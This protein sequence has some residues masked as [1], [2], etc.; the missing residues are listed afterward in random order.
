[1][2]ERAAREDRH[3]IEGTKPLIN[4]YSP[5]QIYIFPMIICFSA[6]NNEGEN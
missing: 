6:C 1:M 4:A 5:T 3:I 2:I